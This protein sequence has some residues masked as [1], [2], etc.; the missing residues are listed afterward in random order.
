MGFSY[1]KLGMLHHVRL[2]LGLF[3]S[4]AKCCNIVNFSKCLVKTKKKVIKPNSYDDNQLCAIILFY[5]KLLIPF[6]LE[7]KKSKNLWFFLFE[8]LKISNIF[9]SKFFIFKHEG[10]L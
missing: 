4:Y 9:G 8:N 2:I 7:F 5:L 6:S 10:S 1:T 3:I